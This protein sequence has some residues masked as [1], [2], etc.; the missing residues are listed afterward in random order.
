MTRLYVDRPTLQ[1]QNGVRR[2][3]NEP[4]NE[5]GADGTAAVRAG[6]ELQSWTYVYIYIYISRSMVTV[7]YIASRQ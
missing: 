2:T 1:E 3:Q 6:N 5:H 7:A 4:A